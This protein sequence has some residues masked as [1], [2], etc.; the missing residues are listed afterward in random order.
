[1]LQVILWRLRYKLSLRDLAGLFLEPGL[2]FT[3]EA[4]REWQARFALLLAEQLRAKREGQAGSSW[5][6]DETYLNLNGH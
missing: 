6:E 5:Y 1:M 2:V 4:V 3:H